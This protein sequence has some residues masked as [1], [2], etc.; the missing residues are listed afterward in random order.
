VIAGHVQV[1]P[2]LKIRPRSA[3]LP[4]EDRRRRNVL[5]GLMLTAD[6][7]ALG[8]VVFVLGVV[9][10]CLGAAAYFIVRAP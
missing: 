5:G 6:V 10:L 9:V 2:G 3:T 8:P 1:S 4:V 7:L